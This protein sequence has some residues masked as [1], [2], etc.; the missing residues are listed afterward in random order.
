MAYISVAVNAQHQLRCMYA[1]SF[2]QRLFKRQG[3][4]QI[5]DKG[6][7]SLDIVLLAFKRNS[8]AGQRGEYF[9][10]REALTYGAGI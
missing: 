8:I 9:P 3:N 2:S 10:G 1:L 4:S 6:I 7:G 5:L